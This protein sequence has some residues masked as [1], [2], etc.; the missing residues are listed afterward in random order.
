MAIQN[1]SDLLVYA[2]TTDPAAQVTRIRILT[3][4]PL[5]DFTIGETCII[6]NITNSSGEIFDGISD[7]LNNYN[8]GG[9]VLTSINNKLVGTYNYTASAEQTE[10]DYTFRDFTNGSVGIVPTLEITNGTATFKENGVI[11]EIVTPGSSAIF[12]PVAYSTSASFSTNMDLRDITNKDSDGWSESLAGLKSFEVSTDLLQS[13]NPDVPLDGTDFFDKLK[14]R[15]IVDLSFSDRIRNIIRTN[16]TQSGVDGFTL[17]D[18]SQL[19]LQSDVNGTNF[20]SKI[21]S[22]TTAFNRLEYT[23]DATRLENKKLTWSF[24]VKGSGSTTTASWFMLS[25]SSGDPYSLDQGIGYSEEIISGDGD[26]EAIS[27]SNARKVTGLS[28]STWTRIAVSL[29][30]PI[31][32]TMVIHHLYLIYIQV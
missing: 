28:T 4:T 21:E 11:I 15:S 16:L 22:T 1:A 20:A 2:K 3:D 6:N 31:S 8:T 32:I 10:G 12:D 23:I 14:A 5:I 19:S 26:I 18:V 9:D 27:G 13:I 24:W 30:L 25:Q 17:N 7:I 29:T